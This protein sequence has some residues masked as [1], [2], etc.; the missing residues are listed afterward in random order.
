MN[1]SSDLSQDAKQ[2]VLIGILDR[3]VA[4]KREALITQK[5]V[6]SQDVLW[7]Q[8]QNLAPLEGFPLERALRAAKNTHLIAEIKPSSPSAGVLK[9]QMSEADLQT[10][11]S[12]YNQAA[13]AI[14]VLTDAPYF[15][16]S[17]ER[18]AQVSAQS[19]LPTLCKD[20]VID[21][22][23][24]YQARLAGA[25]AV[26][27]I[28]K[29]LNDAQLAHLYQAIH[30]LGMTP[31]VEVQNETEL[32]RAVAIGATVLLVNNRD[33]TTFEVDLETT[34]RLAKELPPST[35]GKQPPVLIS[36]SGIGSRQDLLPLL[37][38]TNCFLIGSSLMKRDLSEL[39][40][41]LMELSGQ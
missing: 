21:E 23:M 15:G 34:T 39:P 35:S 11:L 25:A 27:L 40:A 24:V 18:L 32:A 41:A 1:A 37:T 6:V 36:A 9:A 13:S 17:F 30:A 5:Q 38:V 8:V 33:L 2:Q 31:V 28:V 20:F 14:S 7:Q 3:I 29:I 16:G 22:Y 10:I 4:D 12:A 26:L 19:P